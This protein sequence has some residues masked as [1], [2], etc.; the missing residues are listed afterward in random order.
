MYVSKQPMIILLSL[1]SS[2]F[3]PP[4]S[5]ASAPSSTPIWLDKIVC[6]S[7]ST[8]LLTC[9]HNGIG[10]VECDHS[11]DIAL[12]C[13]C[14][15]IYNWQTILRDQLEWWSHFQGGFAFGLIPS[16][17]EPTLSVKLSLMVVY[18]VLSISFLSSW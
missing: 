6:D 16:G 1:P 7:D 12:I 15:S 5:I 2:P 11:A 9:S 10:R 13:A 18:E 8:S 17:P 4:H 3:P 14:K